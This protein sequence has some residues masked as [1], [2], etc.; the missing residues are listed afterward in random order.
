MC[1]CVCVCVC[2]WLLAQGP[3]AESC[4]MQEEG[5]FWFVCFLQASPRAAVTTWVPGPHSGTSG[6]LWDVLAEEQPVAGGEQGR[7]RP[8]GCLATEYPPGAG[9]RETR[10]F[11]EL[12]LS[13]GGGWTPPCKQS[14]SFQGW[15]GCRGSQEM[16]D[17]GEHGWSG[18]LP[19][20]EA[21]TG[22]RLGCSR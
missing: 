1:V 12:M 6:H 9:Q 4:S 3:W 16:G 13:R 10:V 8:A 21:S 7:E 17:L 19:G 18:V 15:L 2:K 14:G 22:S 20:Q 11:K 5:F